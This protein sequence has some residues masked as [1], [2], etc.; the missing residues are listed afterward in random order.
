MSTTSSAQRRG[1]SQPGPAPHGDDEERD[2]LEDEASEAGGASGS[3]P[4]DGRRRSARIANA[5]P[6]ANE[7]LINL[8]SDDDLDSSGTEYAE[9]NGANPGS[10]PPSAGSDPDDSDGDGSSSNGPRGRRRSRS[11]SA[12]SSSDGE[13][14]RSVSP[15]TL[16]GYSDMDMDDAHDLDDLLAA[17]YPGPLSKDLLLRVDEFWAQTEE[18]LDNPGNWEV[19]VQRDEGLMGVVQPIL[20]LPRDRASCDDLVAA[21]NGNKGYTVRQTHGGGKEIIA[22]YLIKVFNAARGGFIFLVAAAARPAFFEIFQ[23]LQPFFASGGKFLMCVPIGEIETGALHSLRAWAKVFE[24]NAETCGGSLRFFFTTEYKRD[25][26]HH[27]EVFIAMPGQ[28]I[29]KGSMTCNLTAAS[30]GM[31]AVGIPT[32]GKNN[33]HRRESVPQSEEVVDFLAL[34]LDDDDDSS[35]GYGYLD[36]LVGYWKNLAS[37][38]CIMW[39]VPALHEVFAIASEKT[40]EMRHAR[41]LAAMLNKIKRQ[42]TIPDS[43]PLGR[44]KAGMDLVI[45]LSTTLKDMRHKLDSV[46]GKSDEDEEDEDKRVRRRRPRKPE[47]SSED[48]SDDNNDNEDDDMTEWRVNISAQYRSTRRALIEVNRKNE[49]DPIAEDEE[50]ELVVNE[51]AERFPYIKD[52][53]EAELEDQR[54]KNEARRRKKKQP[55]KKAKAKR[56]TVAKKKPRRRDSSDDDDSSDAGDSDNDDQGG[57]SK[58]GG[59]RSSRKRGGGRDGQD[60]ETG[61]ERDDQDDQDDESGSA[62]KRRKDTAAAASTDG[63][64]KPGSAKQV[65]PDA[66]K[67]VYAKNAEQLFPSSVVNRWIKELT[68]KHTGAWESVTLYGTGLLD[69]LIFKRL[70]K[71]T[72]KYKPIM[73]ANFKDKPVKSLGRWVGHQKA[74]FVHAFDTMGVKLV[75]NEGF[76]PAD[77]LAEIRKRAETSHWWKEDLFGATWTKDFALE[78]RLFWLCALDSGAYMFEYR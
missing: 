52:R 24:D 37:N 27:K 46:D 49:P 54:A 12:A 64:R 70:S 48:E 5:A 17:E 6:R 68:A 77:K 65:V 67:R 31:K 38:G 71:Q 59:K 42:M 75:H 44:N 78:E 56:K 18:H 34:V 22:E 14:S 72:P 16:D 73:T 41:L 26:P 76:E 57:G 35:L 51:L 60:D 8:D 23:Y 66:E 20:D 28:I 74:G 7:P 58:S 29:V 33:R 62:K 45:G 55:K 53:L 9:P 10:G 2:E 32:T 47:S 61:G 11:G 13:R 4:G 19:D 50:L 40:P 15:Y 30:L 43:T 69:P 3:G 25:S 36:G 63:K 1:A 21:L 39:N